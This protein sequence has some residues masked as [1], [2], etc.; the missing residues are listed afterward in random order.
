MEVFILENNIYINSYDKNSSFLI[1]D[2]LYSNLKYKIK[3]NHNIIFLCIGSDRSTGYSLGPIIG[4]KIKSLERDNLYV[5]GTLENPVY[6]QNITS[7]L[8]EINK[9]IK[10]PF[11][12]LI[13]ACLGPVDKVGNVIMK[14][15][16][17][18]PNI[19]V[20]N[21]IPTVGELSILGVVN[22]SSKMDFT[23]LQT[24]RLFTVMNIANSIS[25]GIHLFI[26]KALGYSKNQNLKF[27]LENIL[28]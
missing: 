4:Q 12:V 7:T 8:K 22:F 10:K 20:N 25:V 19:A 17:L 27:T 9:N 5:Y 2:Y 28:G 3:S 24:T 26:M 21:S 1:R 6:S 16:H 13:D 18:I 14:K 11:I 15:S 23:L